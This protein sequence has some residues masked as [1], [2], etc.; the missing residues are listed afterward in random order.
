MVPLSAGLFKQ[1]KTFIVFHRPDE[2]SFCKT[3]RTQNE[4]EREKKI[5]EEANKKIQT[6]YTNTDSGVLA[7]IFE[8]LMG[9]AVV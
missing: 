6:E 9:F 2:S 5:R 4:R 8:I 3:F 7:Y 1:L